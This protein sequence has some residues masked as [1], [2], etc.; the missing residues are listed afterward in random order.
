M[1]R[2]PDEV[3]YF[4]A[5]WEDW[6]FATPRNLMYGHIAKDADSHGERKLFPGAVPLFLAIAALLMIPP[7]TRDLE[8]RTR[9]SSTG[10]VR[11]L[12]VSI[13]VLAFAT[14]IGA[15]T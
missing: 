4:S 8:R 13:V 15:T 10:L 9:V 12:D 14:Y 2:S 7:V 3:S 5:T 11:L 6:L 1:K